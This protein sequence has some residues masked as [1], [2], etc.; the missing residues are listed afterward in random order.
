MRIYEKRKV[1]YEV[2]SLDKVICDICK[3]V[4][5]GEHARNWDKDQPFKVNE[6]E[7]VYE[8]G[9]NYPTGGDIT[10]IKYDI[11]PYCFKDKVMPYLESLGAVP[12]IS[13]EYS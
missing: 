1:E 2:N 13:E 6:V 4:K 3:T 11:C 10:T 8:E 7:M 12:T 5:P 9:Q